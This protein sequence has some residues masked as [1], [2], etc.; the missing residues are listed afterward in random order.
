M[1][2][3]RRSSVRGLFLEHSVEDRRR[4]KLKRMLREAI[5]VREANVKDFLASLNPV[6]IH[7]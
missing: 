1:L 6:P 2:S 4:R 5:E 3:V 7:H